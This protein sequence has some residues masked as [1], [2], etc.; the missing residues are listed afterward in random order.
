M[1]DFGKLSKRERQIADMV[2]AGKSSRQIA[3]ELDVSIKTVESHRS[4]INAKLGVH[5]SVELIRKALTPLE[6][7]ARA[8]VLVRYR[9]GQDL[10]VLHGQLERVLGREF[11]QHDVRVTVEV[12][13]R[14]DEPAEA[15]AA[16][17]T[18]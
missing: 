9:H 3:T 17:A 11:D 7:L 6:S 1:L 18:G 13:E 4:H 2:V 12:L 16:A 14:L 5:S 10:V 8:E 15:P